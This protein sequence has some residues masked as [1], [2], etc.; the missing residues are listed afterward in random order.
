MYPEDRVVLL[1]IKQVAKYLQASEARTYELARNG[2][3]PV[4]RLGRSLRV[5]ESALHAFVN[6]GGKG[7]DD[8]GND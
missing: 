2:I 5:E 7:L 8:E 1:T 4:V 3:L 6:N